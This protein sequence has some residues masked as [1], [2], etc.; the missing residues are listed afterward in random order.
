MQ[1]HGRLTAAQ[2][3][4][5]VLRNLAILMGAF[6][7]TLLLIGAIFSCVRE[8]GEDCGAAIPFAVPIAWLWF[9]LPM[10]MFGGVPLLLV[11]AVGSRQSR[12]ARALAVLYALAFVIAYTEP[13][14]VR[15]EPL[16]VPLVALCILYYVF[17]MRLDPR[18]RLREAPWVWW[19]PPALA[20]FGTVLGMARIA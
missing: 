20:V 16:A 4:R 12:L 1:P 7:P 18:Q 13:A 10:L 15:E 11:L 14:W 19:V 8:A 3:T 9:A 17:M 6:L 5:W 2:T